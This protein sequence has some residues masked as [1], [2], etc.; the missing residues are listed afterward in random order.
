MTKI[1]VIVPVY[2]VEP[3]IRRCVD[4]I[5]SQ[6]FSD[7]ELILVDDGS[8]DNCG[9]IC[10]EYVKKDS[11]VRVIHKKNGG[12]ASARNA[13]LDEC[14]SPYLTFCDSDDYWGKNWLAA[15]YQTIADANADMVSASFQFVSEDGELI[16]RRTHKMGC[17]S[18]D[19]ESDCA[20]F[21]MHQILG[22]DLGWEVWTRLFKA[23]TIRLNNIRFCESS[24]NFA[25]DMCFVLEYSLYARRICTCDTSE[26]YYVQHDGSMMNVSRNTIKLNAVNEVSKQ[27]GCR[28]FTHFKERDTIILFPA[29]H[30]SIMSNENNLLLKQLETE[31]ALQTLNSINDKNWYRKWGKETLLHPISFYRTLGKASMIKAFIIYT[32]GIYNMWVLCYI[33]RVYC[34]AKRTVE[35][36]LP[37]R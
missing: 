37:V 6:S 27:F 8:P 21:L 23:E 33:Y 5:L 9:A 18:L 3:Y 22:G 13:G 25:E 24:E 11:R 26:Y 2:N 1:S 30:Y 10:D 28:F 31:G 7:F 19:T 4:S 36:L 32:S 20:F 12:V 29:F 15:L 17:Y 16:K 34:F 35:N 14:S